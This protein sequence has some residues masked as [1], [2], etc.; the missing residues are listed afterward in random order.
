MYQE[1]DNRSLTHYLTDE[2]EISGNHV[3][4][5]YTLFTFVYTGRKTPAESFGAD[6]FANGASPL[7]LRGNSR[8]VIAA[9]NANHAESIF[10]R[11]KDAR[12]LLLLFKIIY[13]AA[14]VEPPGETRR[15]TWIVK[16]FSELPKMGAIRL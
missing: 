12:P 8:P 10:K 2:F 11:Q 6:V 13:N 14:V 5:A 1:T 9:Y 15:K 3:R 4:K 16:R 7:L